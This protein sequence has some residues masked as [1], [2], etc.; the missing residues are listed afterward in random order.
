M[1]AKTACLTDYVR[2]AHDDLSTRMEAAR[3]M[4]G[5]RDD[6][7]LERHRIDDFLGATCQHLHAMDE[8]MLPAYAG[9]PDG[10]ALC[11][12]YTASVKR[13]EVLLYHVNAHE[14]GSTFEGSFSWPTLWADV[15]H[16]MAEERSQEERLASALTEALDDGH[17]EEITGR[18]QRVEPTEPTRP[19]PHQP[20]GGVLGRLSRRMM[21]K[22]DAFWDAAQGRIV[23]EQDRVPKKKPGLVGQYFLADP[24]FG[25][26]DPSE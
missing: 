11:H 10:K 13:L 8:V 26:D 17:L 2:S 25:E 20:H 14:Y 4:H 16:A 19:H 22:T 3:L 18:V 12:A 15:E 1:S 21:R 24:R 23:P 7:R 6:P 9:L 5:T